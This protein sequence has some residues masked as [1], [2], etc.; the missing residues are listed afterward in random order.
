MNQ[1]FGINGQKIFRLSMKKNKLLKSNKKNRIFPL[2]SEIIFRKWLHENINR[3]NNKPIPNGK[4]GYYFRGITKAINLNMDFSQPEAELSFDDIETN[5][6]Y[7]YYTIE[8]IGNKKYNPTKGFYDADRT[9]KIYTY[10]N[11]YKEMII[12]DVFEPI[13]K[14]CNENFK[15]DNSLYLINYDGSTEGFIASSDETDI[16]KIIKLKLKNNKNTKYLKYKL[17][18]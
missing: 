5:E 9:D 15:E 8:Y 17:F 6:N 1:D 13:I 2:T 7:D 16:A 14:Y 11:T 18:I 12:T 3:F 4:G 10:Y